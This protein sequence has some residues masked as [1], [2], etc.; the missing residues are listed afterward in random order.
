MTKALRSRG[1]SLFEPPD[2]WLAK[3]E[4]FKAT[5]PHQQRPYSS[6]EWVVWLIQCALIKGR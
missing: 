4:K 5:F 2:D 6:R 3:W 1:P